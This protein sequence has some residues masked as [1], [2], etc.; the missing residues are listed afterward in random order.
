METAFIKV[1]PGQEAE[2]ES[3]LAQAKQVLAKAPGFEVIH[4]HRGI[5]RPDTYLLAIGWARLEDHTVG[6]RESELFTEWRA[7]IG[8][9]FADAPHIEHWALY[10]N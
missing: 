2:F 7:I 6:F 1:R 10:E 8:P 5:E 3:A 9:F 4:V